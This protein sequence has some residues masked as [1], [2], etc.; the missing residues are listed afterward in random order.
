MRRKKKASTPKK[1]RRTYK[2]VP[3]NIP[4]EEDQRLL[5]LDLATF[6]K[7]LDDDGRPKPLTENQYK[8]AIR[9]IIRQSWM[10]QPSKLHFLFSKM[11]WDLNP[12]SRRLK[13]WKCNH[14][15][16]YFGSTEINVDHISQPESFTTIEDGFAWA[17]SIKNAGG[18]EDLQILCIPCHEVKNV[19]DD[20][21]ISDWNLGR[22]LKE[23][24]AIQKEGDKLWLEGEGL[25]PA[26]NKPLRKQQ[27]IDKLLEDSK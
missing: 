27:I 9:S 6:G 15:N 25:V 24:I 14:C 20:N 10:R 16:D 7:N 13:M 2:R 23:T 3:H 11:E 22:I 21:G 17:S 5:E 18:E 12:D 8:N 26:K 19:M 1:T 4:D